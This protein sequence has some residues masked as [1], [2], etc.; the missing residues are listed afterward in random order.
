[1]LTLLSTR[2][3][4]AAESP[5][6][7]GAALFLV[8][9]SACHQP[10]GEG[11]PK[12]FPPLAKSDY[13]MADKERSIRIAI[14]GTSGP[15]T[16]NGTEFQGVMPAP[17]AMEDQQVADVLTYVRNSWGNHGDAVT[18]AE[19]KQVRSSLAAS[20]TDAADP[21]ASLP[22]AP[23]GFKLREV[24]RLPVHGVRLA[25]IPGMAWVLVLNNAGE[26]YRLEPR[27]GNLS[28]LLVAKDYAELAVGKID[29]LGMTIDSK[30]RLYIV[31]N[32]RVAEQPHHINRVVIFRSEPL[33]ATGVPTKLTAWLR[34]S[35]P[36]GNNYYNHGVGHIAEGPDGL[37]YVSSGARTDG[38]E[39]DGGIFKTETIYWKG[40]ETDYTAGIWRIDPN[41]EIPKIEMFAR[42]I[43]NAWS[44]AWNDR[45]ELFSVSNGP[46]ADMPEEMDFVEHGKH[47]GFPYQFADKPATEKPYPYTP[48]APPGLTF[49]PAIRN[50]GPAAGGSAT[51]PIA[52]FDPHSSP[53]GMVF[54]GPDW[55]AHLRGKFLVG[56]FGNFLKDDSFGYDILAVSLQRNSA[57]A[58]E[59]HMDTFFA[60]LARPLDLLQ[61]GKKLYIL[62]YTRPVGKNANRPMNPGRI[63]ELSW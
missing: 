24:V 58:Y 60:P 38:G 35:Y 13:L 63:L 11:I 53:A 46:D 6:G 10:N 41:A 25:T 52:S 7:T 26:L 47:Y 12:I 15:I 54:C 56:R 14:Q 4:V 21:F 17:S 27:T 44:F 8:N 23:A 55:P 39:I 20:N 31:T 49:T 29:A 37:M 42:G 19:V 1:V 62:E 51:K 57:G 36:W 61:V 28:R 9:C 50:F 33:D 30:K 32:Q 34:T 48:D 22:K 43:R 59:A 3:A 45:R 5:A 40:G 16:V 18:A 2:L